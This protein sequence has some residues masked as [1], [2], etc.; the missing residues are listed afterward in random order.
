[1]IG[2]KQDAENLKSN[3]AAFLKEK[4]GLTL[5]AEKT[6]ITHS[7]EP[8]R[9][10]GYDITVSRSNEVKRLKNGVKSRVYYS[11]VKLHAPHEKWKAKLFE[12]GAIRIKKDK[13]GKERWKAI[14]R[15][16]L[17][18]RTD[19]EILSKYNAE[20]RGLANFYSLAC[21]PVAMAHFSSLSKYS[22]LKTFAAKYRTKVSKIKARYMKN[23]AFTVPYMTKSGS[24][25]SVYYTKGFQRQKSPLFGQVDLLATY[26]RYGKPG[27]L[28]QKLYAKTCELCGA[29]CDDIEIHQV[30][31]LKDLTGE[32]QWES[33]M[34]DRRRKTLA[35]CPACHGE[36]HASIKVVR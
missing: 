9:F 18:N 15:G 36:I 12:L 4:L 25:E 29:T 16:K 17:I 30:K 20:V 22:M 6:K 14:H 1:M 26:K 2:S 10:L 27:G 31:R 13:T 35:V 19:I 33:I 5:S 21:N 34:L 24:K 11:V 28:A 23:G 3:L 8:A 32:T 7:A